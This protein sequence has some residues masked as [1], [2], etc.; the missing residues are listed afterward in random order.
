MAYYD[1]FISKWNTL[2]GTTAQKLAEINAL[3]VPGPNQ[4]VPASQVIGYLALNGKLS[5]LQAYAASAPNT[6]AGVAARELVALFAMPTFSTF[7][8]SNPTIYDGVEGFLTALAGDPN[9]GITSSDVTALLAMAAT[10]EP[11]WQANGYTSA[12]NEND[13]EAAGG[14]T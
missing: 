11:W 2:S 5:G 6:T 1:A 10:T 12:F 9:S 3:T 13:L 7:E 14:L 8:M 4:D